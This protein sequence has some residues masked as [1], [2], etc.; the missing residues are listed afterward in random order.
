MCSWFFQLS[1]TTDERCSLDPMDAK[2]QVHQLA[3]RFRRKAWLL[4]LSM[5]FSG[6]LFI[7]LSLWAE[8]LHGWEATLIYFVCLFAGGIA[9]LMAFGFAAMVYG[10][11]RMYEVALGS[12]EWYER[13]SEAFCRAYRE[14][15]GPIAWK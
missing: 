12:V 2:S 8:H 14:V 1:G 15:V 5:L 10:S 3:M 11:Y 4:F 6:L 13:D 7:W 9:L